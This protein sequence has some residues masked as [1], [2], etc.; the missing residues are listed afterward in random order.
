MS[1]FE[2]TFLLLAMESAM[3]NK[4][5]KEI[6]VLLSRFSTCICTNG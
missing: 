1:K 4:I 5:L 6:H 3:T 2:K